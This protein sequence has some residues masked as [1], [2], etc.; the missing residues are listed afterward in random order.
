[1]VK[2][3]Y[4]KQCS[5][6]A[7][8]CKKIRHVQSKLQAFLKLLDAAVV[9]QWCSGTRNAPRMVQKSQFGEHCL[10]PTKKNQREL[11][12]LVKGFFNFCFNNVGS[13]SVETNLK[14]KLFQGC[15]FMGF[16][17][18]NT[19]INIDTV[20]KCIYSGYLSFFQKNCL[21]PFQLT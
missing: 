9:Q 5:K 4:M 17:R 1:M 19:C 14:F 6:K 8:I 15:H 7:N 21:A 11:N 12:T 18:E 13:H 2:K 20:Y 10:F 3:E 16:Q